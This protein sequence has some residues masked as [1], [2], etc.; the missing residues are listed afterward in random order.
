MAAPRRRCAGTGVRA[1][2]GHARASGAPETGIRRGRQ[3]TVAGAGRRGGGSG[4]DPWGRIDT[5]GGSWGRAGTGDA[6]L[7]RVG[8]GGDP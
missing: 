7:A 2:R 8:T 1:G 5:G 4:D 3:G 6:S